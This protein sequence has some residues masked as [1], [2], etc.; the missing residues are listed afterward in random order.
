MVSRAFD[1]K[2]AGALCVAAAFALL[3]AAPAA[4]AAHD[5]TPPGPVT[6]LAVGFAGETT[7]RLMWANPADA[8]FAGVL[9]RRKVGDS[10]PQLPTRGRAPIDVSASATSVKITGLAPGT[11]YSFAAFAHDHDLN[12]APPAT[13]TVVTKPMS[14]GSPSRIDEAA[15]SPEDISCPTAKFCMVV[16]DNADAVAIADGVRGRPVRLG[17]GRVLS[18]SCVSS[19]FCMAADSDGQAFRYAQG[20]W[21]PSSL[22]IRGDLPRVSC[23]RSTFCLVVDGRYAARYNGRRWTKPT[24][25]A[26]RT[27]VL[28]DVSC[29]SRQFCVAIGVA[30]ALEGSDAW[31]AH[32]YRWDGAAWRGAGR[33]GSLTDSYFTAVSCPSS[34]FC[35]TRSTRARTLSYDGHRWRDLGYPGTFGGDISCSGPQSCLAVASNARHV[36]TVRFNGHAW[37][38]PVDVLLGAADSAISC[39]T[40]SACTLVDSLGRGRRWTGAWRTATTILDPTHGYLSD[41]SCGTPTLCM[42]VDESGSFVAY[43]GSRWTRPRPVSVRAPGTSEVACAGRT[44][45]LT[46]DLIGRSWIYDGSRWRKGPASGLHDVP[47]PHSTLG[48]LS[49]GSPT[50]CMAIGRGHASIFNGTKWSRPVRYD[51]VVG[52]QWGLSCTAARFCAVVDLGVSRPDRLLQYRHGKWA[53]AINLPST[54]AGPGVACAAPSTCLLTDFDG[55]VASLRHGTV[56]LLNVPAASTLGSSCVSVSYCVIDAYHTAYVWNGTSFNPG[57]PLASDS[58][59][60]NSDI[61]CVRPTFCAAVGLFGAV[62]GH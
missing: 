31:I 43:D 30:H 11:T 41:L 5:T 36:R 24:A 8:D 45:C 2:I 7:I 16:D 57:D 59:S 26:G 22:V 54:L 13:V 34:S 4:G 40:S 50:F 48:S 21:A 58:L 27:T 52:Q 19:A 25:I 56:T 49:C 6:D 35:M 53:A 14:W 23:F 9:L 32:A 55:H 38:K 1:K 39:A 28:R 60:S 62:I 10:A 17:E 29:A 61:S 33:L 46:V 15:G 12:Y 51:P 20:T 47:R 42:A 44:F 3:T 18:V 37:T